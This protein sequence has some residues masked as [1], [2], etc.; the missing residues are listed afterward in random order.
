M[1]GPAP[2][3]PAV[4]ARGPDEDG[5]IEPPPFDHPRTVGRSGDGTRPG[6]KGP[7]LLLG[8]VDTETGPAGRSSG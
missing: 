8:P 3:R 6:A 2:D 4:V 1:T 7:A 5:A